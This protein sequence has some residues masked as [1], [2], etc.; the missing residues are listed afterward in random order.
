MPERDTKSALLDAA[1]SLFAA[2]GFAA[3]SMRQLAH[4][5]GV[6]LAAAGYHF[7]GKSELAMAVLARRIGPINAERRR[8]LEALPTRPAVGDVARAFLEPVFGIGGDAPGTPPSAAVCRLFGRLLAEQ[9]PFL[10]TFLARQFRDLGARFAAALQRA[11]P[12]LSAAD[13]WWRLHFTAGALAHALQHGPTLAELSGGACRSND[14]GDLCARLVQFAGAG[15][16][17][18]GPRRRTA[19]R[20][21]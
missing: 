2:N 15:F 7:G 16:A 21:R 17:G 10:R 19:R 8:R 20:S 18:A 3:T 1:E 9:P 5:A 13:V 4:R 6:N 14:P 12:D 11:R